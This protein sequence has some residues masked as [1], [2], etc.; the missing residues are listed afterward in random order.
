MNGWFVLKRRGFSPDYPDSE[1]V[2]DFNFGL[3]LDFHLV[4]PDRLS[5]SYFDPYPIRILLDTGCNIAQFHASACREHESQNPPDKKTLTSRAV[6]AWAFLGHA[7]AAT[8]RGQCAYALS[9]LDGAR[10]A[11]A[12][13]LMG[14]IQAIP[15]F[16]PTL[17]PKFLVPQS[18]AIIDET[19]LDA[20][21]TSIP[22][23]INVIAAALRDHSADL[24]KGDDTGRLARM[25]SSFEELMKRDGFG[26]NTESESR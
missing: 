25:R 7:V 19:T 15:P 8:K 6:V 16:S 2:V 18:Q 24:E 1:I 20:V 14:R 4:T 3:C 5:S 23:T 10:V 13:I 26:Y 11:L 12:H 9:L 17:L 22:D 21:I